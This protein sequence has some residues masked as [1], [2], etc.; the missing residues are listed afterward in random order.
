MGS[1]LK[2]IFKFRLR[3]KIT[4]L[5]LL[6]ILLIWI[7]ISV[8]DM[9]S[10]YLEHETNLQVQMQQVAEAIS[11]IGSSL[12]TRADWDVFQNYIDDVH[13][14][15]DKVAYIG[16]FDTADNL[17]VY[18][19]K[20]DLFE[21]DVSTAVTDSLLK[22]YVL[23]LSTNPGETFSLNYDFY[24][25]YPFFSIGLDKLG[26]VTHS[27]SSGNE[28]FGR[29]QVGYAKRELNNELVTVY[30]RNVI[31]LIIFIV[32][33]FLASLLM[34]YRLTK[35]L[36]R[37]ST[38]METIPH[39]N[40]DTIVESHTSDEIGSLARSFNYMVRELRENNFFDRFERD[41]RKVFTLEKIFATLLG[42]LES[43]YGINKGALFIKS[44]QNDEYV[45]V[46]QQNFDVDFPAD[47][48]F[49]MEK[50]LENHLKRDEICFSLEGLEIISNE[51]PT[52]RAP[53]ALAGKNSIHW[54]V[55]LKRQDKCFGVIYFGKDIDYGSVDI[56]EKKYIVNLVNHTLLPF[57]VALLH[58]DLTEQERLK[59]EFEIAR[60][61]QSNLLPQ[62][63]PDFEGYDIFGLCLP[64]REVGGDYFDYVPLSKN[65]LGIVIADVAGK[66][67]SA[68]FYM[69]EI[70]GMI[71]SLSTLYH[72]PKELLKVLNTRMFLNADRKVFA[73]M[74]FG[75]LDK[76]SN[77]FT[78]ARAG[79]NPLLVKQ[80]SKNLVT[81]L[82]PDGLGL[83]L[84]RGK[85]FD[86]LITEEKVKLKEGDT[87]LLYTDGVVESMNK[88]QIEFGE[89]RL[90]NIV[91]QQ[92]EISSETGC[93]EILNRLKAYSSGTEQFDDITMI[94]I[95][96][97]KK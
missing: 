67:T 22:D 89:D 29:V 20:E 30:K 61:V 25:F 79:H 88:K 7:T 43:L 57:E 91:L 12:E 51:I 35:P 93:Q 9:W 18:Y 23:K 4:F 21:L 8:I 31:I 72:S 39:G 16:V 15:L 69:A 77:S 41:L 60:F 19:L 53:F 47:F 85:I 84:D 66:S 59:K 90:Q 44:T 58:A 86:E 81:Y 75:V 80:D 55:F 70:K 97:E 76:K 83:G 5:V 24:L 34:S 95:K 36:E 78:F 56:E 45:G 63:M 64:A 1:S 28:I 71:V 11:Q 27:I 73:S 52:L 74:I 65:K 96:R 42:R 49:S 46:Y 94:M 40:M 10:D 17:Q 68:A 62:S 54:T 48:H 2:N 82:T 26:T 38:A 92:D 37:L 87:L 33:G 3:T 50:S 13:P 6:V 14:V 32:I